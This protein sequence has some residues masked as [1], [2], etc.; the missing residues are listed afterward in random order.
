MR[1]AILGDIHGNLEALQVVLADAEKE[2]VTNYVSVGDIV[3]YGPNPRECLQIVRE[4]L[5]CPCVKGNHDELASQ[6]TSTLSF[7]QLAAEAI[8]WTRQQLSEDDKRYLRELRFVRLVED[9]TLVHS[10]LDMPNRW[11]YV[12]D[13][14]AAASSMSY[15]STA[16][17]FFGHTHVPLAFIREGSVRTERDWTTVHV[18]PGC[19]YFINVG[20]VGQPRDGIPKSAYV[21]YD[22]ST[23][24]ITLKRLDY[25]IPAVQRKIREANLPEKLAQRLAVGK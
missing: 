5:K 9:F 13:R 6:D 14:L 18:K 4:Q 10:T 24:E 21:I 12:F 16:V 1:F 17:C 8:T 19:R 3:G 25:D 2:R 20:S 22:L 23:H 15:Q 7:N 11:G